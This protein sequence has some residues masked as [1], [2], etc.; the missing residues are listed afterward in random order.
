MSV[1]RKLDKANLTTLIKCADHLKRL[2]QFAYCIEVYNKLGDKESIIQLH[3]ETN[4]WEEVIH[5]L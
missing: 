4:N 3:V 1:A 5:L 2:K